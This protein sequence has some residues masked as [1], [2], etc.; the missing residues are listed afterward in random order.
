MARLISSQDPLAPLTANE[1]QT[2]LGERRVLA[3]DCL[4]SGRW[5]PTV[6][7]LP[8]GF[9]SGLIFRPSA[10]MGDKKNRDAPKGNNLTRAEILPRDRFRL[11]SRLSAGYSRSSVLLG[12]DSFLAFCRG[13]IAAPSLGASRGVFGSGAP[14]RAES[15]TNDCGF[16]LLAIRC[17]RCQYFCFLNEL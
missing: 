16:I 17:S 12:D 3:L 15:E 2:P 9:R 10:T 14:I 1:S 13:N 4:P 8:G 5:I 7:S 11:Q 6:P